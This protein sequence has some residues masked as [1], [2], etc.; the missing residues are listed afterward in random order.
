M[1]CQRIKSQ[2]RVR[3]NITS[4]E[5]VRKNEN[6]K[7]NGHPD[8]WF[9]DKNVIIIYFLKNLAHYDITFILH[10]KVMVWFNIE[11]LKI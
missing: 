9:V 1:F 5:K 8:K 7:K 10:N 6:L 2:I 3:E 11:N 4:Q